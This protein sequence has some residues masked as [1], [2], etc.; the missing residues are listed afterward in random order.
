MPPILTAFALFHEAKK[1]EL[2]GNG[3]KLPTVEVAE[4]WRA[5]SEEERNT[6]NEKAA[7][8]QEVYMQECTKRFQE[9][10]EDNEDDGED[11]DDGDGDGENAEEDDETSGFDGPM[12][13]P[14][15]RVKKIAL[16]GL[17]DNPTVGK[18]GSEAT[19]VF[20]KAAELFVEHLAWST[21]RVMSRDTKKTMTVNHMTSA[22]RMSSAPETYQ[23]FLEELQ[24]KP[25]PPPEPPPA[26][27]KAPP[28]EKGP[29]R[30][31]KEPKEKPPPKE[32]KPEKPKAP[33]TKRQR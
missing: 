10:G 24:P 15:G 7:S 13:F 18:V 1:A 28:K 8:A 30:E 17:S 26:K 14:K 19:F 21:S 22:M 29:P 4:Y 9:A 27:K 5:L 6:W 2:E 20:G 32:P 11:G 25:E 16:A 3:R 23:Y 12:R 33:P 31:K